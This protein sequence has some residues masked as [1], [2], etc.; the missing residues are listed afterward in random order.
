M[1]QI[2]SGKLYSILNFA[3]E[4]FPHFMV[5]KELEREFSPE[6]SI[7]VA[8]LLPVDRSAKKVSPE[9]NGA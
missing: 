6:K 9:A 2:N 1:L 7:E 4:N 3:T 5:L 8:R